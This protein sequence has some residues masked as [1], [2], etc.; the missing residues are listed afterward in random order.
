MLN[1]STDES[2]H[3]IFIT[4]KDLY[5]ALRGN[6]DLLVNGALHYLKESFIQKF[7]FNIYYKNK[8]YAEDALMMAINQ[9]HKYINDGKFTLGE[10]PLVC[11]LHIFFK[12]RMIDFEKKEYKI[13][14]TKQ[15]TTGNDENFFEKM[16]TMETRRKIIDSAIT[17]LRDNCLKIL[18]MKYFDELTIPQIAET[19][20]VKTDSLYVEMARCRKELKTILID[21]FNFPPH[22]LWV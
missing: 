16:Q 2:A 22:G 11:G 13:G 18:R 9:F 6:N 10:V 17:L 12:R 21:K 19:T 4:D 8:W 14:L 5:E 3:S 20:H 15:E 1:A 7:E